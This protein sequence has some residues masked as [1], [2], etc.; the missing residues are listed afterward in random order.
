MGGGQGA[1]WQQGGAGRGQGA[2]GGSRGGT[3]RGVLGGA[4]GRLEGCDLQGEGIGGRNF[5]IYYR[6]ISN[7]KL[8]FFNVI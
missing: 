2:A 5:I 7:D 1:R 8:L 6:F 4:G 3:W